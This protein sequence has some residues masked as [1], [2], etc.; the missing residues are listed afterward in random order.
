MERIKFKRGDTFALLGSVSEDGAPVNITG[1][2]ARA[3]LR[4]SSDELVATLVFSIVSGIAG[5]YQ[6]TFADSTEAWP[7]GTLYGDIEFTTV[8]GAIGSTD[9]FAVVVIRDRTT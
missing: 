7:L 5:T 1:W 2:T 6:F 4:R 3:Q 9:D 8:A